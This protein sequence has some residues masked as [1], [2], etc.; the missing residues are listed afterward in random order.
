MSME[1]CE[2]CDRM[3]DLDWNAEHEHFIE[4]LK[5]GKENGMENS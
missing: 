4:E 5:G 3:I 1:Y 2:E